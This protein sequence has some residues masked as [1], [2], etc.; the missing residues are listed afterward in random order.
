MEKQRM[1][2]DLEFKLGA[3]GIPYR[4]EAGTDFD[5]R[6]E[7]LDAT[8]GAGHKKIEY[9]AA[10]FL[11]EAER[12]LY[13]WEFV[14]ETG[15]GFSFAGESET[16]FQSGTT[17]FRKIKSV[18]YGPDGK[19]YEYHLDLGSITKAFKETARQYGWKF[20]V[21][22][23]RERASYPPGYDPATDPVLLQPVEKT[24]ILQSQSTPPADSPQ[25]ANTPQDFNAAGAVPSCEIA[26][27][28]FS[29]P[30]RFPRNPPLIRQPDNHPQAPCYA[31]GKT[32]ASQGKTGVLYWIFLITLIFFDIFLYIGGGGI[33]FF[34]LAALVPAILFICRHSLSQGFIRPVLCCCG[35]F[36][37][38]V[39]LFAITG[40]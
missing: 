24:V 11:Y 34:V 22:L 20:K 19:A 2:D 9:Q 33:G 21:V 28:S 30:E 23:K 8:W 36:L 25:Q 12:T 35:A 26:S 13:F 5:I 39:I 6:T 31:R 16:S 27:S 14:K 29:R 1:T 4:K 15:S 10:A 32:K 38:T 7:F 18:G 37:V 40:I 17:L 3:M